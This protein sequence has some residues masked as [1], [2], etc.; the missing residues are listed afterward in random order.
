[1]FFTRKSDIKMFL[2]S[3]LIFELNHKNWERI[4][5][6]KEGK[7]DKNLSNLLSFLYRNLV[8]FSLTLYYDQDMGKI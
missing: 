5:D 2:L 6:G 1:M 3:I 7:Q 8:R 4:C